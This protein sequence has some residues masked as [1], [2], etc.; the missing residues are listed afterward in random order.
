MALNSWENGIYDN[1]IAPNGTIATTADQNITDSEGRDF[2]DSLFKDSPSRISTARP[3]AAG[4]GEP[5]KA[6]IAWRGGAKR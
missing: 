6:S 1:V 3:A 2:R 5:P 4:C